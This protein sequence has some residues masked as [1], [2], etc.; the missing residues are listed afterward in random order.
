MPRRN[1]T[2]A[3]PPRG[4]KFSGILAFALISLLLFAGNG[5]S[6]GVM[7]GKMIMG[8][9]MI[10]DDF[11]AFTKKSLT[12]GDV[13]VAILCSAPE[14]IKDDFAGLQIELL[15]EVSRKMS[16]HEIDMVK[17]HLVARW[18]DDNGGV[19]DDLESL[20]EEVDADYIVKIEVDHF[21]YREENSPNLFRGRCN[22]QVTVYQFTRDASSKKPDGAPKMV[23]ERG[24]KSV[25]PTH[26]P[27]PADQTSA[28]IFRKKFMDRVGDEIARL[29]FKHRAGADF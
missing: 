22:G 20:A 28:L 18:I 1:G 29:F 3:V 8:D 11:E 19:V 25:H 13:K 21:S 26:Q 23:Y 2:D 10:G 7:F 6:L 17:P 5:C 12:D 4:R 15:N 16:I 9:P 14:S 27:V 24:F